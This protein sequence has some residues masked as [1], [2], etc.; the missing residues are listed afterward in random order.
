MPETKTDTKMGNDKDKDVA[1]GSTIVGN[2]SIS[3]LVLASLMFVF[4]LMHPLSK[5]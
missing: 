4:F 3:V 5:A 1:K 2:I